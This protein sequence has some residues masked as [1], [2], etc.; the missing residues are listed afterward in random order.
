MGSKITLFKE[1]EDEQKLKT[2]QVESSSKG[3]EGSTTEARFEEEQYI[4]FIINKNQVVLDCSCI[5]SIIK[6]EKEENSQT[7][8]NI[9]Y[10]ASKDNKE[11]LNLIEE[12]KRLTNEASQSKGKEKRPENDNGNNHSLSLRSSAYEKTG[13]E[14]P[15]EMSF[16]ALKI[17]KAF[18]RRPREQWLNSALRSDRL[19]ELIAV[20]EY[21][22]LFEIN[23]VIL[24]MIES[25]KEEFSKITQVK[26]MKGMMT[27]FYGKAMEVVPCESPNLTLAK[28]AIKDII[29]RNRTLK[30][31]KSLLGSV[32]EE[33]LSPNISSL[34]F[35]DYLMC[36]L[37]SDQRLS[38]VE[39]CEDTILCSVCVN[40]I[41]KDIAKK[42]MAQKI[43]ISK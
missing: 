43:N 5:E 3:L 10:S 15:Y 38:L 19:L 24:S 17:F 31:F 35:C 4:H 36:C 25:R 39:F 22:R 11:I 28:S 12:T 32:Q 42:K 7:I 13:I 29:D 26:V 23:K 18:F 2:I 33:M 9:K 37:Y 20:F 16:S 41:I 34:K 30:E 40:D 21:L 1:D 27:A 14:I 6:Y 8:Y